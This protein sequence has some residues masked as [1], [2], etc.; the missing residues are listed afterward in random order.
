M[1]QVNKAKI[2][3]EAFQIICHPKNQGQALFKTPPA[4][5]H[6][7]FCWW[8][9]QHLKAGILY[10]L[11][12]QFSVNWSNYKHFFLLVLWSLSWDEAGGWIYFVQVGVEVDVV[13]EVGKI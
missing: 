1:M 10:S 9:T 8:C 3:Y 7:V 11:L 4:I 6:E 5:F 2:I 12:M 13:A